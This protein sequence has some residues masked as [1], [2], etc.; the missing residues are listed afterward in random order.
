MQTVITIGIVLLAAGYL[1]RLWLPVRSQR[2]AAQSGEPHS[3]CG[4]CAGCGGCIT[5]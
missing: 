1:G 4:P 3:S 2:R 5:G